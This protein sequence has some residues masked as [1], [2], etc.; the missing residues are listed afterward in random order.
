MRTAHL[1][2]LLL[3][4]GTSPA[5][6]QSQDGDTHHGHGT[7]AAGP[8]SEG[9]AAAASLTEPGQGAFAAL[10][11][12]VAKLEADPETDWGRVDIGALRDH[13]VDMDR[14]VTDTVAREEPLPNGLRVVVTGDADTMETARRMI[15]AHAAELARD[16]RWEVR[17]E[18]ED[19]AV[20]L[21]VTSDDPATALRI[22]ALGFYGLMA[23][24]DH[25]RAHHYAIA[26]GQNVH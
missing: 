24:Q 4:T 18:A 20:T 23:S 19:E 16:T 22:K 2:V 25:H 10:S 1:I 8:R 12:V 14:I 21:A 6:A 26:T 7:V 3:A 17:A 13:L 9:T 11:E 5:L 15:P